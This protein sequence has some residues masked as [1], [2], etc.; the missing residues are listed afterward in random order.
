LL[1]LAKPKH[2]SM[3]NIVQAL[4]KHFN[5]APFEIADSFHFG[6]R[7][8]SI[9]EYVVALKKLAIHCNFG[10]F[11]NRALRDRFVCGLNNV[12]IQNKLYC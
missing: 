10:E 5:P 7:G 12:K 6:T 4:E 1:V 11:L 8:E 2:T 3:T 9:G